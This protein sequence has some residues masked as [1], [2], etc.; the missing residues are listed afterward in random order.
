MNAMVLALVLQGTAPSGGLDA[1]SLGIG[2][3]A[4]GGMSLY[5]APNRC[6][7]AAFSVKP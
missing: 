2:I 5:G 7:A 1:G 6:G 3:D 4:N